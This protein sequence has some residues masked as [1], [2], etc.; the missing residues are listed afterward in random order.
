MLEPYMCLYFCIHV[1][2]WCEIST[3]YKQRY[4]N[5]GQVT[6]HRPVCMGARGLVAL[7]AS[8]MDVLW[9]ALAVDGTSRRE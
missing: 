3:G 7:S 1:A 2:G 9:N 6:E 8:M 4:R 5:A